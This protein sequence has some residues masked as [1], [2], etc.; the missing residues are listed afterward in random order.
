MIKVAIADDQILLREMLKSMLV[1]DP[2]IEVVGSAADGVELMQVCETRRP[3]VILLDIRMPTLD[4]I[5]ALKRIK[6]RWPEIKVIIL[7]TFN[8][9]R[10]ILDVIAGKADGYV[11]KDVKPEALVMAVK[12]AVE[13]LCVIHR[14]VFEFITSQATIAS[15]GR[16]E[17]AAD[18]ENAPASFDAIDRSIIRLIAEGN[19][20]KEIAV[21]IDFA[22]GSVK[23]RISRML[24]AAGLRDRTHI[25]MY[26]LKHSLM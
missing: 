6:Q 12:C 3:Q 16:V 13:D 23:N 7:S 10:D 14:S 24:R 17:V 26:A 22:E 1:G 9:D 21:A 2:G 20:N 4:G 15:G 5:G 8:A 19:C 25:V 11:L 18:G